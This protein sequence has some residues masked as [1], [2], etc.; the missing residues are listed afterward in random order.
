MSPRSGK[1]SLHANKG[2]EKAKKMQTVR[3]KGKF[4]QIK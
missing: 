4:S 1:S 2:S 3:K